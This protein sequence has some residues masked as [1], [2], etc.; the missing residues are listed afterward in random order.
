MFEDDEHI[1]N[2]SYKCLVIDNVI[3]FHKNF[4]NLNFSNNKSYIRIIQQNIRSYNKNFDEFLVFLENL[5]TK[6]DCIVLTEAWLSDVTSLVQ[7]EGYHVFSSNNSLNRNDGIVIYIDK[8]FSVTC[9]QLLLGSVATCL[10]LTFDWLGNSCE[11]VAVY[12]SPNSSLPLFIEGINS[13]FSSSSNNLHH[14]TV[15]TGD[16][17]CDILT[18]KQNSLEEQYLDVLHECGFVTCIDKITRPDS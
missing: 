7:M 10:S 11:L 15:F 3:N 2:E 6:F 14:I 17:N 5:K 1:F 13:Y 18:V 8:K 4:C 9:N 12:R 16:A